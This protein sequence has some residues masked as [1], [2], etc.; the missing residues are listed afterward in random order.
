MRGE[1]RKVK[2]MKETKENVKEESSL[3]GIQTKKRSRRIL[4]VN[5]VESRQGGK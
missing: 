3:G 5:Y 4:I 2:P 1:E